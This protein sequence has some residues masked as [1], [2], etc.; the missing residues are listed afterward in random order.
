M[1]A[2]GKFI[3]F[4]DTDEKTPIQEFDKFMPLLSENYDVV[5]GSRTAS[6][7]QIEQPQLLYR[8]L[9]SRGIAIFMHAVLA[10]NDIKHPKCG[11]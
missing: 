7:S 11:F 6:G 1:Q 9:G 3:G 2:Q 10:L 5:I 8:Q 4:A